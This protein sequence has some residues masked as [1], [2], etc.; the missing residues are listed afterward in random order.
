MLMWHMA[1]KPM[2]HPTVIVCNTHK[3]T[4]VMMSTYHSRLGQRHGRIVGQIVWWKTNQRRDKDG[5]KSNSETTAK[6]LWGF[7]R[8]HASFAMCRHSF[9]TAVQYREAAGF[10]PDIRHG[11][12]GWPTPRMLITV[13]GGYHW[14]IWNAITV[15]L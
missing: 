6:E 14:R 15:R 1:T 10:K 4:V 3:H 5:A 13:R 12:T 8:N 11:C 7:R 2:C 9:Y